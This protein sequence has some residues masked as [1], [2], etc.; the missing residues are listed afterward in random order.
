[1]K[2]HKR[3]LPW[4]HR[5]CLAL[6]LGAAVLTTARASVSI[7]VP[8]EQLAGRASL[9]VQGTVTR[10]AS[11][12]DASTGSL[13]TY[14][15]LDVLVVHRGPQNL[16]QL[17]IREPGGRW[18]DLVHD[19][20]AVPVYSV[21]E[22]VLVFL[23]PAR[24]GAL[25]T[26]SMFF[27][28]FSIE[29]GSR[30]QL[31]AVRDLEGQG[32]IY[33][34][35]AGRPESFSVGDLVATVATHQVE[36]REHALAAGRPSPGAPRWLAVPAELPRLVWD[37]VRE[38]PPTL[39]AHAPASPVTDSPVGPNDPREGTRFRP[40]SS[41]QPTRW[42]QS[43]TGN[44]VMIQ[45]QRTGDP[46]GDPAAAVAELERAM[47]AWTAVPEAR[48]ALAP[49]NT[50]F[51]FT[52]TRSTSPTA[53]YS[54][55]NIVLFND[56]YEDITDPTDCSG[57][58]AIG[59]YWRSG[60]L[61]TT[62][63][64]VS[65]YSA[66]SLYVIFNDQFECYL[67][68]PDNLAEVAAHE[69]GHGLGFGHSTVADAI[70]RSTAYGNR[71]PRLGV[72]DRDAVHCHYPHTLTLTAPNG[73][74]SWPAGSLRSIQW[75]RSAE[76][77]SNPGVVDLE[78]S[79][80]GGSSWKSIAAGEPNDGSY[81]WLVPDDPSVSARARVVR[82]HLG[83]GVPANYP[84]TCSG[85]AS[86]GAFSILAALRVAGTVPDGSNGSPLLLDKAPGGQLRLS[87]DPS[88]SADAD[89]FAIYEG[90]LAALRSGSWDHRPLTCAA[91]ADAVEY[92]VPGTADR[93]YLVAPMAG[94]VEGRYGAS[95][96]GV[97]RPASTQA[98]GIREAASCAP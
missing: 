60:S 77:G 33:G 78:Y 68:Q 13:A 41:G 59:G 42:Q 51:N 4:L 96:S 56:P 48:I 49:G 88:C 54:S 30:G 37:D 58:L 36:R 22:N 89:N 16:T 92:V 35:P 61:S 44:P 57:V 46:L 3:R 67:G 66:L 18:G 70:M 76:S 7:Y 11:G 73:G 15:S 26:S 23:E 97:E 39:A 32:R 80:D 83:A 55:I 52:A 31:R 2:E 71:G 62:I 45:I 29:E 8:P 10:V 72:D 24:D 40:S 47:A 85:D 91:G 74:Q 25:R 94:S 93:Y 53:S 28:K 75:N 38:L 69:L 1:M 34:R 82:H 50:N 27:G 95:S 5:A 87:W 43:D 65:F 14:V 9:V 21:G 20:D 90:S 81:S 6:A 79:V 63:N 84:S 98:C 12:L 86:N 17:V 19:L 64:N